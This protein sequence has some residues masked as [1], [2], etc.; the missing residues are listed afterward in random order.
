MVGSTKI[1]AV[2]AV[3]SAFEL[4]LQSCATY[5]MHGQSIVISI[6]LDA[7]C[8][9]VT[10][11]SRERL[12]TGSDVRYLTSGLCAA[13]YNA[14]WKSDTDFLQVSYI[15]VYIYSRLI[16]AVGVMTATRS[17]RPSLNPVGTPYNGQNSHNLFL[18]SSIPSDLLRYRLAPR[19]YQIVGQARWVC[20]PPVPRP[21]ISEML[22]QLIRQAW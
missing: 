6:S 5:M 21:A 7:S 2:S 22:H 3:T 18:H 9:A 11:L 19:C 12:S 13:S 15:I 16:N 20:L 10:D 17:V 8:A 4:C 14:R 1:A